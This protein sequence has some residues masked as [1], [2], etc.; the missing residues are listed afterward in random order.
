M[1]VLVDM[2]VSAHKSD[3]VDDCIN[4]DCTNCADCDCNCVDGDC[5]DQ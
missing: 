1:A 3:C 5:Y 4:P 2:S